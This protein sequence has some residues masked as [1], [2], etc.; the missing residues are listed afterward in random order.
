MDPIKI[1]IGVSSVGRFLPLIA[2]AAGLFER[3]KL[4]VEIVNQRNEERAVPDIVSGATPIGTPNAP[5]LVFSV[6]E[7][8]DLVIVAGL[9]NRPAFYLAADPSI[10]S[11]R[12]LKGKRIG[13][14]EPKR[15]AGMVMLA[16]LRKWGISIESDVTLVDSGIN[17]RSYEVLL[18]KKIDAALLPPEKAFLAEAMGF[19]MIANS[20][21]LDCHWVPLATTRRF[22]NDHREVVRKIVTIYAE[23]VRLF[24][25]QPQETIKEIS[26]WLPA[27]AQHPQVVEKCYALF[28][29]EFESSIL[30]SMNSL[31]SV[32]RE[33]AFQDARAGEIQPEA[34]VENLL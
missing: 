34:L 27:L 23:S 28:A 9:L 1:G 30:P 26:R 33:V 15:M 14:N 31:S 21:D 11:V 6:L 7:G 24:K 22:L 32:L 13:I 8:S 5:S 20:L 25:N 19:R 29:R 4:P 18:E 16:L 17:D 2:Q 10:T 3:D 12:D